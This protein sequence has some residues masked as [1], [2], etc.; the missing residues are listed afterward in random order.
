MDRVFTSANSRQYQMFTFDWK[1]LR[2]LKANTL[3]STPPPKFETGD[4]INTQ[5]NRHQPALNLVF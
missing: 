5:L 4:C 3:G 2:L 1:Q